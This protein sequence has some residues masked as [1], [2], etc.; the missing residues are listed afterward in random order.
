MTGDDERAGADYDQP[1]V[2]TPLRER[3]EELFVE[4][5]GYEAASFQEALSVVLGLAES[6]ADRED[7]RRSADQPAAESPTSRTTTR[8]STSED[9]GPQPT[10]DAG[11]DDATDAAPDVGLS[12]PV[13]DPT[14]DGSVS[15]DEYVE[16]LEET[17]QNPPPA[18]ES[19]LDT[20]HADD[21]VRELAAEVL[22]EMTQDAFQELEHGVDQGV[23]GVTDGMGETRTVD[24]AGTAPSGSSGDGVPDSLTAD[25]ETACA[26]CGC[27]Y[28]VSILLTS[29]LDEDGSVELV[30]PS[31]A[32]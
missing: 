17:R 32:E 27:S 15:F 4:A 5:R 21:A 19:I 14:A 29:I 12:D 24:G 2:P 13:V 3:V 23:A 22:D 10:E 28:P 18:V 16:G 26:I 8:P 7:G 6:S 11:H 30:C 1:R 9:T 20:E 31:C 25:P